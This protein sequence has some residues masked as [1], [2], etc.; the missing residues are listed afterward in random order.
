MSKHTSHRMLAA[1]ALTAISLALA[2]PASAGSTGSNGCAKADRCHNGI[3]VPEITTA[4]GS[5]GAAKPKTVQ[6]NSSGTGGVNGRSAQGTSASGAAFDFGALTISTVTTT[7]PARAG[8]PG[9]DGVPPASPTSLNGCSQ[10]GVQGT[11]G[12]Q[13]GVTIPQGP[14]SASKPAAPTSGSLIICGRVPAPSK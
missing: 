2:V 11:T 14:S 7:A 13:N 6:D 9:I 1:L 12:C 5:T 8:E 3:S 10:N 4:Q